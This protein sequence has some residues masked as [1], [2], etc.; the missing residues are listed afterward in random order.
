MKSRWATGVL[1]LSSLPPPSLL[2][3]ILRQASSVVTNRLYVA[4][5]EHE[6]LSKVRLVNLLR[7]YCM[8]LTIHNIP[9]GDRKCLCGRGPSIS[10]SKG[11]WNTLTSPGTAL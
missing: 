6:E 11:Q 2:D 7:K 3:S 10:S 5:P 9:D 1:Q 4:F 8:D